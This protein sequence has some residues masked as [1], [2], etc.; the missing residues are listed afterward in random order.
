MKHIVFLALTLTRGGA[1]R[2]IANL[3]NEALSNEYRVSIVTCMNKPVGYELKPGIEHICI[4]KT[5]DVHY[6]NLGERFLKRRILLKKVLEE[7][8]PDVLLCFLPEPN[9]L[10]LSLKKYFD[11]PMLISVRN[12]PAR[13][14]KNPVYRAL[15]RVL[16]PKA[17]GY[18]FQTKQ[19]M[20]YFSFS[21]H[22]MDRACVIPN[23][24]GREFVDYKRVPEEN[25]EKYIVNV[26]KLTGQKN[27]KLLIEA[28]SRIA[29][30]FPD[31][32][33]H[34]Y[35]EGDRREELEAFVQELSL[36][37]RVV[38]PGNVSGLSEKIEAA[39]LFVLS[40]DYEGMPNALMEAM[41]MGIPCISTNCPCGGSDYLI[42]NSENGILVP[43]D[44]AEEL[45]EAMEK[46]LADRELADKLGSNAV[47]IVEKLNP[48]V[49]HEMWKEYIKQ[50]IGELS[51]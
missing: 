35:G 49:I 45:A 17:D 15:M 20:E 32:Q 27:Q 28:F 42:R 22:I 3:C 18:I 41:A 44:E 1:E 9:F 37:D 50:Y 12:D 39:A 25:R 23:P 16:Y 4:E 8:K 24:L 2:V 19:A 31:Y 33:L 34:I 30:K 29:G 11:F 48:D 46:L 13:E 40:S 5:S 47:G 6:K 36:K 7:C 43:V 26:G 21:K 38:M 10:A 51:K 14:Y